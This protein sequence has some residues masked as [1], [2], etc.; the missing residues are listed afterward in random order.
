ME[1]DILKVFTAATLTFFIG[2]GITPIFTHFAYKYSWWK[3]T[4]Q[5]GGALD[6]GSTPNFDKLYGNKEAEVKTPRMG[7]VII[8]A[9]VLITMIVVW[10]LAQF[11]PGY[12]VEK[13]NFVSRNQTWLPIFTLVVGAIFGLINDVLDIKTSEKG[14]SKGLSRVQIVLLVTFMGI[15]GGWWFF[16]KLEVHQIS[17]PIIGLVDTGW[18]IIPLFILFMLAIYSG[19]VIDGIDGLSGGV[20]ASIFSAYSIIAFFQGQIDIATFC[21][22]LVGGILSYLW[23]NIPPARFWMTETGTMALTTT[24]TVVAFLT[25]QI[26]PLIIIA[27]PLIA[28][29]ASVIIQYFWK[30]LFGKKLF[31]ITPLHHHFEAI[32]WPS[33]KVTMRYWILGLIFATIGTVVALL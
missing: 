1:I 29:S 25:D 26:F 7:G 2:I 20:F 21:A 11:I 33:H 17:F 9:S 23:F 16:S 19:G 13:L 32:G 31:L 22:A 3:K 14:E 5:K 24:I 12:V 30:K 28:T 18:F 27:F 4:G 15:V 8:W 10:I 6:G